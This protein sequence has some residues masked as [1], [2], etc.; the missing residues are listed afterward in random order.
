[1]LNLT[2]AG[3]DEHTIEEPT[4]D[5][6]LQISSDDTPP[7][8]EH[9]VEEIAEYPGIGW[10]HDQSSNR[11]CGPWHTSEL[12]DALREADSPLADTLEDE[13]PLTAEQVAELAAYHDYTFATPGP[14][15]I[16]NWAGITVEPD[17]VDVQISVGDPRGCLNMKLWRGEHDGKP[18]LYLSV[19][20]TDESAPHVQLV[21]HTDGVLRLA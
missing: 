3:G 9:C 18:C 14:G 8:C 10:V 5:L 4:V 20:H 1:M 13:S 16:A 6:T 11:Q 17:Y 15:P 12:R 21:R 2:I 19:P 7:Y